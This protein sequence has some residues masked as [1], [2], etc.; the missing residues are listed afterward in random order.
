MVAL[1]FWIK[2]LYIWIRIKLLSHKYKIEYNKIYYA[3]INL[4]HHF[5]TII[6]ILDR[7]MEEDR[8]FD[9]EIKSAIE[10]KEMF[11]REGDCYN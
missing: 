7:C 9:L 3:Y 1:R 8:D 4:Y 11:E 5:P 10:A 6:M 2:G